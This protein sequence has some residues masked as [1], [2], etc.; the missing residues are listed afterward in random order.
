MRAVYASEVSSDY[1]TGQ[2]EAASRTLIEL[3][4]LFEQY[5]DDIRIIGGWVP[6]LMFPHS[7]HVGSLDVDLLINHQVLDDAGYE[8]MERL[9]LNHGYHK[10]PTQFFTFVRCVEI[11]GVAYHVDVDILAGM[12]GGTGGNRHSQHVQ[13]VKALKATGGNFAFEF[14]PQLIHLEAA[15]PDGSLDHG[16]IRVVAVV[17]FLVMKVKALGR[18]KAKD[19]YDIYFVIKNFRLFA[20]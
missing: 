15:R 7:G 1:G 18:G 16:V 9:L 5:E 4:S 19:A 14:A 17:P 8:T 12:Y 10:H 3:C 13:G 11:D 20:I 2:A 6:D